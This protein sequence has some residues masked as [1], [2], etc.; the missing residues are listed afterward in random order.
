MRRS[1]A[2]SVLLA[3]ALAVS[4]CGLPNE[5]HAQRVPDDAVP[6]GLLSPEPTETA[7]PAPGDHLLSVFF[8]R[9][10]RLVR[11]ERRIAAVPDPAHALNQLVSGP[12]ATET[13]AGIGT[14]PLGTTLSVSRGPGATTVTVDLGEQIDAIPSQV[15]VLAIAQIV[16]TLAELPEVESVRFTVAGEPVDVLRGDGSLAATPVTPDDYADLAPT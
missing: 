13:H 3:V 9:Q 8:V 16:Y 1:I 10:D 12:T 7:T 5:E 2:S 6:F 15:Q 11:V 14:S 4:G